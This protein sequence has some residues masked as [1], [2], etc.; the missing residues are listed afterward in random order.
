MF[1]VRPKPGP[2][3]GSA[4]VLALVTLSAAVTL[5]AACDDTILS[6]VNIALQSHL[7]GQYRVSLVN[8]TL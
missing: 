1:A 4:P 2:A 8:I 7:I 3:P 6:L 5:H